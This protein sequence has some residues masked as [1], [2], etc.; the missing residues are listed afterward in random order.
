[1]AYTCIQPLMLGKYNH[2]SQYCRTE[3]Y[4]YCE[5]GHMADGPP[6]DLAL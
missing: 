5:F 1:M 4:F 2:R 3:S 6:L